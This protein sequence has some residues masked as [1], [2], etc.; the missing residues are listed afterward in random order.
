MTLFNKLLQFWQG[1][2]TFEKVWCILF[3]S[4]G[5]AVSVIKGSAL[6]SATATICGMWCVFLVAKGKLSN[7]YVGSV[8]VILHA[9]I[10]WQYELYISFATYIAFYLPLQYIGWRHWKKHQPLYTI[11]D[12]DIVMRQLFP[13]GWLAILIV[14]II[15]S[16]VYIQLLYTYDPS[17]MSWDSVTVIFSIVGQLLMTWR[18]V[19][20]WVAWLCINIFN[21]VWWA[22]ILLPQHGE[23]ILVVMWVL[24]IINALYGWYNWKQL[25]KKQSNLVSGEYCPYEPKL[26]RHY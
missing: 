17:D 8:Y 13:R 26:T 19:E 1:C 5:L 18:F 21:A 22:V 15:T 11:Q 3:T 10:S 2:T 16:L 20:Q 7:F 9:I 4:C 23:M 12:E 6:L 24:K 25:G 14:L